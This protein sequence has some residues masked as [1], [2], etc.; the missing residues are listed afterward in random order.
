MNRPVSR[1]AVV[2]GCLALLPEYASLRDPVADL[3]AAAVEAV[4]WLGPDVDVVGTGSG[5]RVGESL[6]G[7]ARARATEGDAHLVVLNG[8]ACRTEK[9]PGYLDPRAEAYDASLRA[10]LTAADAAALKEI[11][12]D[13]GVDLL[14]D[15]AALP[16][17]AGLLDGATLVSVDYDDAPYGVQYWVMRWVRP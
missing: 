16:T 15:V 9:A 2:P 8:S 13:L 3:R 4:G 17:L 12:L 7:A 6:L 5:R 10:A 11:D 1:V 14:A